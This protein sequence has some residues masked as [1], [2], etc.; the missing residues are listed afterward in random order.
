M[1]KKSEQ[2]NGTILATLK[3]LK[4]QVELVKPSFPRL[5]MC[6]VEK[7]KDSREVIRAKEC[8]HGS[9]SYVCS[10]QSCSL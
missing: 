9:Q 1:G 8:P 5:A 2:D 4:A 6:R 3:E 10:L 7:E